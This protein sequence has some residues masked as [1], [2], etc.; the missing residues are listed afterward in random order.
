[1]KKILLF[2]T[3]ITVAL[4]LTGCF[5][6][7]GVQSRLAKVAA[8]RNA[9]NAEANAMNRNF[10]DLLPSE[11]AYLILPAGLGLEGLSGDI[12]I[13][14]AG[15]HDFNFQGRAITVGGGG[16]AMTPVGGGF[17]VGVSAPVTSIENSVTGEGTVEA[18]KYY[19]AES[20]ATRIG[21]ILKS[22]SIVELTG[23]ELE[24]AKVRVSEWLALS[25]PAEIGGVIWAGTNVGE[26]GRFA[27]TPEDYGSQYQFDKAQTACPEGWRT[28]TT[29]EFAA[30]IDAGDER[31][32]VSGVSGRMFGSGENKIFLPNSGFQG[33]S[34]AGHAGSYWSSTPH[35][36]KR[37]YAIGFNNS[38][39]RV[40]HSAGYYRSYAMSV[41][42]VKE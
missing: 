8:A 40:F 12:A 2:A 19:K 26:Q 23:E 18:G 9:I 24:E 1:M 17:S 36:K 35:K 3:I 41:R 31:T 4:L 37:A 34:Q 5:G 22:V 20:D 32:D 30:L 38:A 6:S 14:P 15:H 11:R 28:P 7:K 29:E 10:A 21:D 27:T 25:E 33:G 16:G 42:C 13:L 39:Q